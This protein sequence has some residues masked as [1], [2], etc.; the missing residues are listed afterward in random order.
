MRRGEDGAKRIAALVRCVKFERAPNGGDNETIFMREIEAVETVDELRA[1]SH[2]DFFG[3][4]IENVEG[5]AAEDGVA[6]RGHLFENVAGSGF[7][8]GTIPWAPFV[9]DK[10]DVMFGVEF[11]YHLPVAFDHGFDAVAFAQ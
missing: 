7:A 5:H 4:T 3:M 9:N 6:E 1:V 8:S 2:G 10:L 11:A